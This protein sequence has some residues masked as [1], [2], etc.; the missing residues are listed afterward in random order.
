MANAFWK[1]GAEAMTIQGAARDHHTGIKCEGNAVMLQG[2]AYAQPYVISAIGNPAALEAAVMQDDYLAGYRAAAAVPDISVGLGHAAPRSGSRCPAY[3]GV[4]GLHVRRAGPLARPAGSARS[5][6]L[7]PARQRYWS[8]TAVRG[9]SDRQAAARSSRRPPRT[10]VSVGLSLGDSLGRRLG[11]LLEGR[12]HDGDG[13]ALGGVLRRPA[14]SARPR[15]PAGSVVSVVSTT[16]ASKPAS[17]RIC[18]AASCLRPTTSGHLLGAVGVEDVTVLPSGTLAPGGG[19]VSRPGPWARRTRV[20]SQIHLEVLRP[21]AS[22]RAWLARL[23]EDVRDVRPAAGRSD[24]TRSTSEPGRRTGRRW[25]P[26]RAPA[27]AGRRDR[28]GRSTADRRSRRRRA[29]RGPPPRVSPITSGTRSCSGGDSNSRGSR[30]AAAGDQQHQEQYR[31]GSAG[32][33]A[34]PAARRPRRRTVVGSTGGGAAT[35][36]RSSSTGGGG[37]VAWTGRPAR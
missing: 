20:R 36:V 31:A 18:S 9:V 7:R 16:S 35:T 24:T 21:P 4:T 32:R 19:S 8:S 14:G 27:C 34:S 5:A 10:Q 25:G 33:C 11:R 3:D 12:H 37:G 23:A 6:A 28:C 26:A 13:R 30:Y 2:V 22:A 17:R 15:C 1:G 29:R